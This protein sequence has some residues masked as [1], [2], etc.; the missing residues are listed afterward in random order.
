MRSLR[1]R[2]QAADAAAAVGSMFLFSIFGFSDYEPQPR[3]YVSHCLV[4]Q[5]LRPAQKFLFHIVFCFSDF[6][7][8]PRVSV[9]LC[10]VSF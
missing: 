9:L 2:V 7:P 8:Q 6:G 3:V 5:M 1:R 4:S 10:L